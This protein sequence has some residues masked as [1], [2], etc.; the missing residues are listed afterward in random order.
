MKDLTEIKQR[1][2]KE[3]N[4][5]YFCPY[6]AGKE[7]YTILGE[8][9]VDKQRKAPSF[10]LKLHKEPAQT[11]STKANRPQTKHSHYAKRFIPFILAEAT[12][13]KSLGYPLYPGNIIKFGRV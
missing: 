5:K 6:L 11:E 12:Q 4:S 9:I 10:K 3:E 8:L 1:Q 13:P 7:E 2:Q